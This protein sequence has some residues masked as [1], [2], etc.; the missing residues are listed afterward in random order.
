[1]LT[2]LAFEVFDDV[3]FY[4]FLVALLGMAIVP[5]SA[6]LAWT[7]L[8][9]YLKTDNA[10]RVDT[11]HE[12]AKI[13]KSRQRGKQSLR[14]RLLSGH[15]LTLAALWLVFVML[16][17][18]VADYQSQ[19]LYSF[20][21][22]EILELG[23]P[24]VDE[25]GDKQIKSAYRKLSVKYH[26]DKCNRGCK[27]LETKALEAE[28]EQTCESQFVLVSKAYNTLTDPAVRENW[29]KYGNPDGFQG[30]SVT[31]GLPSWMVDKQN[32]LV[33]LF[34]YTAA[35][36]AIVVAFGLWWK[37]SSRFH[38]SGLLLDT[39]GIY[40]KYVTESM[41]LKFLIEIVAASSENACLAENN[42]DPSP[43]EKR[44]KL[45]V[46]DKQMKQKFG[47]VRY[48]TLSSTLLHAHM[49]RLDMSESMAAARDHILSNAEK[50][51]DILVD[52]NMSRQF[53]RP[54]FA[55]I[56]LLQRLVQGIWPTHSELWQVPHF[57]ER[58]VKIATK[59]KSPTLLSFKRLSAESRAAMLSDYL[60]ESELADIETFC[61]GLPDVGMRY[62][63]ECDDE[64]GVLEGDVVTLT[65]QLE[66]LQ[67]GEWGRR[68]K[69]KDFLLRS[70]TENG[71]EEEEEKD[72]TDDCE[73]PAAQP[74][75]NQEDEREVMAHAPRFPVEKKE[76]WI[77]VLQDKTHNKIHAAHRVESL[78]SERRIT[79]KIPA[80]RKGTWHYELHACCDSYVGC[81]KQIPIKL[82]VAK[83]RPKQ[84]LEQAQ[85]QY[86]EEF[87]EY[88]ADEEEEEYDPK[89]Y[90]LW[91]ESFGEFVFC[92]FL[93][94]ILFLVLQS[95]SLGQRYI[96]PWVNWGHAKFYDPVAKQIAALVALIPWPFGG[97]AGPSADEETLDYMSDEL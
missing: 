15:S 49:M 18:H 39:I 24:A 5:Y 33:I 48:I 28:C 97:S 56:E 80:M 88:A 46:K 73:L 63:A 50:F 44:L 45:Q 86:E 27:K 19:E 58:L 16:L 7:T 35:L 9:A 10:I 83:P 70:D 95:S 72:F 74:K 1:M 8:S 96:Q 34:C 25:I 81:D 91:C 20:N 22:Y 84:E 90:Y 85:Q 43:E 38:K 92:L 6:Y 61:S 23:D 54:A 62:R 71:E 42:S 36:V 79:L 17:V 77:V 41:A 2:L 64:E 26:P 32:E 21:P 14:A 93:L 53:L 12:S 51:L 60:T 37:K 4:W 68:L 30:M 52:M 65:V 55:S 82:E 40:W 75:R 66:R 31:I 3:A 11:T 29:E 78:A 13:A 87:A 89:W 94:W 67:P 59:K 57:T 76:R 69:A 47:A